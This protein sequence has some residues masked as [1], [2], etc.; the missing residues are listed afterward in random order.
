MTLSQRAAHTG[1]R[2]FRFQFTD[3]RLAIAAEEVL[4]SRPSVTPALILART[5]PVVSFR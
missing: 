3:P 2:I 1:A 4:F 5:S